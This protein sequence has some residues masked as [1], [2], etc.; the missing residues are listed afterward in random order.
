MIHLGV[1]VSQQLINNARPTHS[2]L[3]RTHPQELNKQQKPPRTVSQAS[4]PPSGK[5]E[6]S[7]HGLYGALDCS[8]GTVCCSGTDSSVLPSAVSKPDF[9]C[10]RGS[11]PSSTE[12]SFSRSIDMLERLLL[13][14]GSG[15]WVLYEYEGSVDTQGNWWLNLPFYADFLI[16]TQSRTGNKR[17]TEM[18]RREKFVSL[19]LKRYNN[20]KVGTK[21]TRLCVFFGKSCLL[22]L[23]KTRGHARDR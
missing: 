10:N 22:G 15:C 9:S 1:F 23:I 21:R 8:V 4:V 13:A 11:R 6:G 2:G 14:S 5:D 20:A 17:G 16:V 3:G 18:T 19:G 12:T 7:V